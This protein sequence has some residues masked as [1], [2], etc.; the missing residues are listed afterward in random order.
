MQRGKN[1][2]IKYKS[3]VRAQLLQTYSGSDKHMLNIKG[4]IITPLL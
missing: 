1:T 3:R 2:Q 4:C